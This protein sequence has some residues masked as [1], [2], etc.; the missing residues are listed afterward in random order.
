MTQLGIVYLSILRMPIKN[1]ALYVSSCEKYI[2]DSCRVGVG[3]CGPN[4]L[5][6]LDDLAA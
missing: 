2:G 4:H 1:C 5:S 6:I 3:A